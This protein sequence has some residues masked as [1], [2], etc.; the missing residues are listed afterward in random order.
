MQDVLFVLTRKS[1]QNSKLA[2]VARH[3]H[4]LPII[5][6]WGLVDAHLAT[7]ETR[8]VYLQK[9]TEHNEPFVPT[10]TK[11]ST[12]NTVHYRNGTHAS[13]RCM[14]S[15]QPQIRSFLNEVDLCL[16][17]SQCGTSTYGKMWRDTDTAVG[18]L[19]IRSHPS[20]AWLPCGTTTYSKTWWDADAAWVP[21]WM[22]PIHPSQDFPVVPPHMAKRDEPVWL[23]RK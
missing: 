2:P 8:L 9:I 6:S 16:A 17:Y 11:A 23:Y 20:L 12:Y 10:L 4:F 22:G 18:S 21:I 7:Y 14:D 13:S 19:W 1:S 3:I 15:V 5:T